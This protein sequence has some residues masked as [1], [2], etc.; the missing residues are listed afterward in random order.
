VAFAAAEAEGI[1]IGV[2]EDGGHAHGDKA[3]DHDGQDIFAADES[4]VKKSQPGGHEHDEAG[5]DQHE[6]G[7]SGVEM[8][9]RPFGYAM[10]WMPQRVGR[11]EIHQ[12]VA[13]AAGGNLSLTMITPKWAL[14]LQPSRANGRSL[15][16]KNARTRPIGILHLKA[17]YCQEVNTFSRVSKN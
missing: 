15:P 4:A 3:L 1:A 11:K 17:I 9:R 10:G 16:R 13:E 7:I 2:P 8:H 12:V 14:G 5:G 6:S